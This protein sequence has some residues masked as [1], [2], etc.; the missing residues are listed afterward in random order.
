MRC[1]QCKDGQVLRSAVRAKA[2][3]GVA[4]KDAVKAE[5]L[6]ARIVRHVLAHNVRFEE[7][8][9]QRQLCHDGGVF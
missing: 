7:S 9:W 4:G 3:T 6:I 8:Q 2:H 5:G 1:R